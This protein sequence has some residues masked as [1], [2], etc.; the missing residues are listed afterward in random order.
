MIVA[1]THFFQAERLIHQ[2]HLVFHT[3]LVAVQQEGIYNLTGKMKKNI[4]NVTINMISTMI[5]NNQEKLHVT[6]LN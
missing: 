5:S 3:L 6:K 2:F 1:T 4:Y